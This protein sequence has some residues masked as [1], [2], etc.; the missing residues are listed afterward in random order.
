MNPATKRRIS[1]RHIIV[2]LVLA[3]L[4]FYGI[5]L[6]T[7]Q[8]GTILDPTTYSTRAFIPL[9]GLYVVLLFQARVTRL[10]RLKLGALA[11]NLLLLLFTILSPYT[12]YT[13]GVL[14]IYFA[15]SLL[16]IIDLRFVP[17]REVTL[18]WI[19]VA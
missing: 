5:F 15:L 1:V 19:F 4:L 13:F 18:R 9:I 7:S 6:P 16:F 12:E 2:P 11:I 17:C 3:V 10:W 14:L 8:D